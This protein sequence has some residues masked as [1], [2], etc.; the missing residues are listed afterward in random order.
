MPAIPYLGE[1]AAIATAM[2]WC[3]CSMLFASA[4]LK[5]GSLAV[6]LL[7]LVVGILLLGATHLVL[8]GTP[9]PFDAP[10]TVFFYLSLSGLVGLALGDI[11]YFKALVL[12]GPRLGTLV[13]SM[14]P[15]FSTVLAWPILGETM[16]ALQLLGIAVTLGG[17]AWVVM[18]RQPVKT[19]HEPGRAVFLGV[20][21]GVAGAIGQATAYI[22]SKK[23]LGTGYDALSATMIRML[24]A[25]AAMWFA[26]IVAGRALRVLR[27][28]SNRRA[29]LQVASG[30]VFGPYIGVWLS[31]VALNYTKT[32]IASTLISL[33][34]IF[35]IPAVFIVYRKTP[36]LR[37]VLG[38]VVAVAGVAIIFLT[39]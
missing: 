20:L 39:K 10:G 33:V 30:A 18:E 17:V 22:L 29:L 9:F 27:S 34:P 28:A 37:A 11:C 31:L 12:L 32:G 25:T 19:I 26:A 6:N 35:V 4:G 15:V 3:T 8:K 2:S 5:I 16:G 36:S 7:R 13:M 38:A 21:F 14:W 24:T 1:I 23:G